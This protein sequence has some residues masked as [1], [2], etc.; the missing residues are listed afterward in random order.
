MTAS[1]ISSLQ[2]S[3]PRQ[4]LHSLKPVNIPDWMGQGR[5]SPT[6]VVGATGSWW[7]LKKG[8]SL[9]FGDVAVVPGDDHT[10]ISIWASLIRV[11]ELFITLK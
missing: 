11:K 9:T 8:E 2:L 5:P 7:L 4:E 6:S 3:L 1:S 10:S